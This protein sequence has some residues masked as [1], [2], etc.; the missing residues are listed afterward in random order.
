MPDRRHISLGADERSEAALALLPIRG[1]PPAEV[2]V[3]AD[4]LRA[5][6]AWGAAALRTSI[7][8]HARAQQQQVTVSAPSDASTWRLL[9]HLLE[10]DCPAHLRP[11]DD[12]PV[13]SGGAPRAIIVPATRVVSVEISEQIADT[14]IARAN[15]RLGQALRFVAGQLPEL[16]HNS[17]THAHASPT[18]P[19]VCCFHDTSE[20]E[21]QLVVCDLGDGFDRET[22]ATRLLVAVQGQP[23]G[24][25]TSAAEVAA[26]RG[27]D[28]TLTLAAG[29]ARLYW[30]AGTWTTA[31]AVTVPGFTAAL[32]VQVED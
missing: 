10:R 9:Y 6:D 23:E 15:G 16:V 29:A 22:D 18:K 25:L 2:I 31:V 11:T 27:L 5:I 26:Q 24:A 3:I 17:L 21:V 13:P 20:D 8:F 12:A 32:A 7:E 30:R 28:A 1:A 19:V 4:G 14:I